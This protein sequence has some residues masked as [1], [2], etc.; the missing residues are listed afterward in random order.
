M[1]VTSSEHKKRIWG[2][3]AYDVASQPFYTLLL[4]FIFGPYFAAIAAQYF[5]GQGLDGEAARAAAQTQWSEA[6][7]IIG[8]LIAF[9][10]P[11]LG[12]FADGT[13]RRMPWI[14]LFSIF[15][16]VGAS[17]LW[18]TL[19]DGSFLIGALIAFGIGL[20]GAEFTTI[21]T[22]PS[23]YGFTNT[24]TEANHFLSLNRC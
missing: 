15:Y 9:T 7:T 24:F 6:L 11:I 21:F 20:I 18:L 23:I 3:Y 13:G 17:A 19:P 16:I 8:L 4:T 14:A 12:A 5:M 10:A 22:N 1:A 2:W